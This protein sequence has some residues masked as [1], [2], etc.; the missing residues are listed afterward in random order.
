MSFP[1]HAI[2]SDALIDGG[3]VLYVGLF[4]LF[5]WRFCFGWHSCGKRLEYI[6]Y[7]SLL[8]LLVLVIMAYNTWG[9]LQIA[10]KDTGVKW[11]LLP[12]WLRTFAVVA[13]IVNLCTYVSCSLQ[14][15]RHVERIREDSG[16]MW[17]KPSLM[18]H[19]RA[20]QIILLPTVYSVMAFSALTRLYVFI[21]SEPNPFA[22]PDSVTDDPIL[23][24]QQID[25][26]T[27]VARSK[28][29]FWVG[30]LYESWVLYQFTELVFEVVQS[31]MKKQALQGPVEQKASGIA[32]LE[33]MEAVKSLAWLG[34]WSFLIVCVG[35]AGYSL[36]LLT[37][38]SGT[39][40][41]AKDYDES[42]SKFTLAGIIASGAAIYNVWK[43]ENTFHVPYLESVNPNTKFLVVKILVSIAFLQRGLFK[44]V[45]MANKYLPQFLQNI[46]KHIPFISQLVEF[47]PTEFELFYASMIVFE[48]FAIALA[49]HWAWSSKEAW[50]DEVGLGDHDVEET[51]ALLS[52]QGK[53]YS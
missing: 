33:S 42:M 30:D 52:S 47:S 17:S 28:T 51:A 12:M 13:P 53:L 1:L 20:V 31:G 18:R 50:Y 35:E 10:M 43:V 15:F 27:V 25:V 9:F 38:H 48:C 32:L 11:Q 29:C 45:V 23:L 16:D 19:D 37:F 22:D 21:C 49:H 24:N 41:S 5:I 4:A 8:L 34:V 14:T 46:S 39:P 3:S 44:G 36:W 26:H 7:C 2:H 40:D 6:N